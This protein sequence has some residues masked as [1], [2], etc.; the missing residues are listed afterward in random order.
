MDSKQFIQDY[1]A[2]LKSLLDQIKP[3]VIQRII[4]ELEKTTRTGARIYAIGNGGS[5]ATAAHMANDFG[6]GLRRREI[7]NFDIV[8]LADNTSVCT[9]IAND[10]G[11]ENIFYMQLKGLLTPADLVLAI[12]ASGNSL[13]WTR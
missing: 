6:A 5:A 2:K 4:N 11:Y 12:S 8:S 13:A 1:I 3:E 10:I 7:I 9:A